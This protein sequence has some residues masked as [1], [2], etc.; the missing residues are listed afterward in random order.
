M[1]VALTAMWPTDISA[2]VSDQHRRMPSCAIAQELIPRTIC[3]SSIS[4]GVFT[5]LFRKFFEL[6]EASPIERQPSVD[7]DQALWF[8][9]MVQSCT[10]AV[11]GNSDSLLIDRLAHA[12]RVDCLIEM[13][14]AR[15]V[16]IE[17][18]LRLFTPPEFTLVDDVFE[19]VMIARNTEIGAETLVAITRP[20]HPIFGRQR[21]FE[22]KMDFVDSAEVMAAMA[23]LRNQIARA[24]N[25]AQAL[26]GD[27]GLRV[28]DALVVEYRKCIGAMRNVREARPTLYSVEFARGQ[29]GVC[30]QGVSTAIQMVDPFERA[31]GRLAGAQQ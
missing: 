16:E 20:I 2:Q 19:P 17:A 3:D 6:Y 18:K 7:Q 21:P 14:Q 8:E 31:A 22:T 12:M 4:R 27:G 29:W 10:R 13:G 15:L 24:A 23:D 26:Y 5:N 1:L 11:Y 9:G 30:A 25:A 28:F